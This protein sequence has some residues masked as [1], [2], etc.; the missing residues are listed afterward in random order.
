MLFWKAADK[1][2]GVSIVKKRLC[3]LSANVSWHSAMELYG[4]IKCKSCCL[5]AN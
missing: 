4:F 3:G 5:C 1:K 2:K